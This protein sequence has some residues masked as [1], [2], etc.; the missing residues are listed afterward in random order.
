M[1]CGQTRAHHVIGGVHQLNGGAGDVG[2]H[3]AVGGECGFAGCQ[4]YQVHDEGNQQAAVAG[5]LAGNNLYELGR[6]SNERVFGAGQ[7]CCRLNEL[8]NSRSGGLF[9][10]ANNLGQQLLGGK[11]HALCQPV[12]LERLRQFCQLLGGTHTGQHAHLGQGDDGFGLGVAVLV[13]AVRRVNRDTARLLVLETGD[14]LLGGGV[15][16]DR[17]GCINRK[18]FKEEGEP[19]GGTVRAQE[20]GGLSLNQL[21]KRGFGA[22]NGRTGGRSRMRANPHLSLRLFGG[23]RHATHASENFAGS[24]RIILNLV[25]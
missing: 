24:P 23:D 20:A 9:G 8:L 7:L 25:F 15:H 4:V 17:Q 16:L 3:L 13:V 1:L 18:D 2:V 14:S 11:L 10:H 5:V 19:V 6:V 12:S 22:V 21:V